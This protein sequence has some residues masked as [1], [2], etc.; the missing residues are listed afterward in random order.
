MDK[1][2]DAAF[3]TAKVVTYDVALDDLV[4]LGATHNVEFDATISVLFVVVFQKLID[5]AIDTCF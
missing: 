3:V 1:G 5:Q 4:I 2:V